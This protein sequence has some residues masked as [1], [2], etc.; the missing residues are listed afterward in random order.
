[1][2]PTMTATRTPPRLALAITVASLMAALTLTPAQAD[3][4]PSVPR[5]PSPPPPHPS[6]WTPTTRT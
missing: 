3:D 1:M 4:G 2:T 6:R 5:A